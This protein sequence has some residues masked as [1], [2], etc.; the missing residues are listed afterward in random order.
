MEALENKI[1]SVPER[2]VL[3]GVFIQDFRLANQ[4]QGCSSTENTQLQE[5]IQMLQRPENLLATLE[6][7]VKELETQVF[8]LLRSNKEI[9]A[10]I[11]IDPDPVFHDAVRENIDL[12]LKKRQR[13]KE[14][15]K[16]KEELSK[17]IAQFPGILHLGQLTLEGEED[18]DIMTNILQTEME[19]I[20]GTPSLVNTTITSSTTQHPTIDMT[21]SV[22]PPEGIYL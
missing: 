3:P 20:P 7:D 6:E 16:L 18:T 2:E 9:L 12:I 8:H 17:K 19:E 11:Q 15:N 4:N 1:R 22:Q 14:L 10:E 13:I 5:T 21:D